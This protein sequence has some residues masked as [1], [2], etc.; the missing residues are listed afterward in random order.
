[1]KELGERSGA[2]KF[3]KN[4]LERGRKN[5]TFAVPNKREPPEAEELR[6]GSWK[7]KAESGY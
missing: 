6:Q 3:I 1:L 7:R 5:L 2:S 4:N